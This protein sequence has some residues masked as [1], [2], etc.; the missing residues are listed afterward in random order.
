MSPGLLAQVACSRSTDSRNGLIEATGEHGQLVVDHVLGSGYRLSRD[1]REELAIEAP[2]MT[3]KLLLE[4]FV[5]D[6]RRDVAPPDHVSATGSRRW[7]WPTPAIERWHRRPSR[8]CS[9]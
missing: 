9:H 2:R 3:V 8:R 5:E 1:G 7:R 4:R 6:A